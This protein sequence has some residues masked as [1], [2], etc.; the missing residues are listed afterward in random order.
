MIGD[1]GFAAQVD[2]DD[3]LRLAVVERR[4]DDVQQ[5]RFDDGGRLDCRGLLSDN[6]SPQD[7]LP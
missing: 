1:R 6:L 3:L 5:G 2:G 7:L 4:D